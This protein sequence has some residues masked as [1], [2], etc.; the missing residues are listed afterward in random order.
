MVYA[1]HQTYFDSQDIEG[2]PH[3]LFTIYLLME[4]ETWL[5]QGD[6]LIL[7][8]D[9]NEDI[10]SF[11]HAIQHTGLQEAILSR[12]GT[13]APATFDGGSDQ[14]DSIF[15]LPSID[16]IIGGYFKFGFCPF[17]D[18]RGLWI[19]I[20]YNNAFGHTMPAIITALAR[21]L[22]TQDP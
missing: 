8:M 15:M 20:H 2:C 19:D 12:H 14:I 7:L 1:Q 13:N 21:C 11:H 22:K 4:V 3:E 17:T 18:H 9:T 16:I 5:Q 10:R 6:Q